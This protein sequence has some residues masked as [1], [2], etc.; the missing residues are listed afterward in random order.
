MAAKTKEAF[1][2]IDVLVANAGIYG[3]L[4]PQPFETIE[5]KEWDWVMAVNLK[6]T[7]LSA[8]AVLPYMREQKQGNIIIVS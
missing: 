2:R 8:R 4:K 3:Q 1:G 6:G 7:F 5:V